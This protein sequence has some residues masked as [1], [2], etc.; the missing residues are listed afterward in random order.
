MEHGSAKITV[1]RKRLPPA[2]N[3]FRRP[4]TTSV[5]QER[6]PPARNGFRRPGTASA[7]QERLTS[8]KNGFRQP[9]TASVSQER[10]PPARNGFRRPAAVGACSSDGPLNALTPHRS[11]AVKPAVTLTVSRRCESRHRPVR[12]S[13][14]E[15]C[16]RRRRCTLQ[17]VYNTERTQASARQLAGRADAERW[18]P[19]GEA[20]RNGHVEL[21]A[22]LGRAEEPAG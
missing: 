1:E 21:M 13:H 18:C 17:L 8:A 16:R 5:S 3:G 12:L 7:G 4:G 11:A 20:A 10:L 6:L 15:R 19:M 22:W 14:G 9:G 2:R